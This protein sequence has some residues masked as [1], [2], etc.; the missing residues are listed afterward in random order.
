MSKFEEIFAQL[1]DVMKKPQYEGYNLYIAGHSLGG[2]L[3][4]VFSY[5]VTSKKL[6]EVKSPVTNISIASPYCGD[7]NWRDSFMVSGEIFRFNVYSK[8]KEYVDINIEI[9]ARRNIEAYPC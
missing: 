7:S 3:S 6:E 5:F 1:L 9:G 8:L 2:A 4:T